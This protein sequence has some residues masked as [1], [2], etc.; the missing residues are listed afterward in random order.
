VANNKRLTELTVGFWQDL[1]KGH[2]GRVTLGAQYEYLK[3]DTFEGIGGAPS[4]DDN[5]FYTSIRYYPF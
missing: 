3:R 1:Y 2:L 5:V 4:T